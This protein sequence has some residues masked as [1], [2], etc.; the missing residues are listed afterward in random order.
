MIRLNWLPDGQSVLVVGSDLDGR[1][2]IFR[3]NINTGDVSPIV[4]EGQGFHCP[5]C[6]PDGKYMFYEIDSWEDRVFKIMR[7]DFETGKSQ[8]FYR[9]SSQI[10]RMDVSP[11]G[12]LLAFP[13]W[14]VDKALKIIPVKGGKPRSI[15]EFE[16]GT[17]CTSVAWSPNG[18]YLFISK[19]PK[20]EDKRGR[21]ELW[22]ISKDGGKAVKYP[23][24]VN[25]MGDLCIHPDGRRL[26]FSDL[27]V[28][29]ATYVMENFLPKDR[30]G[31]D[32]K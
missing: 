21:I 3:V 12:E 31:K 18:N 28:D 19:V 27:K 1:R 9:S 15:H 20:G 25:G 2:G 14:A 4:T 11:D 16:E 17:W 7:H 26:A 13:E 6:T 24:E 23:L 10:I 32:S 30:A 8:E 5:R 29:D 22:R